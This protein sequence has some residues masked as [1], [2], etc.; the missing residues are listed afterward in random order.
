MRFVW[1][2]ALVFMGFLTFEAVMAYARAANAPQ[3]ATAAAL[4]CAG[5]I[6]PYVLARCIEGIFGVTRV[7]VVETVAPPVIHAPSSAAQDCKAPQS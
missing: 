1:A 3:Q 6:V 2:L 4:I 5:A 7:S